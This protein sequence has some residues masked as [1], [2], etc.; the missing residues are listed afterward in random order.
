MSNAMHPKGSV[1]EELPS[2]HGIL[3]L[4]RP[5][6]LS[7]SSSVFQGS[8]SISAI[9]GTISSTGTDAHRSGRSGRGRAFI[10][11]G[12]RA[13]HLVTLCVMRAFAACYF[14][15]HALQVRR[16]V[17]IS[18][19]CTL[20]LQLT[21]ASWIMQGPDVCKRMQHPHAAAFCCKLNC[22]RF[23][24]CIVTTILNCIAFPRQDGGVASHNTYMSEAAAAC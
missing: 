14:A 12:V 7:Q 15:A 22:T 4:G 16:R 8:A 17:C 6:R 19:P 3:S 13:D 20:P 1:Q 23:V 9:Q 10:L 21:K 2:E 18:H 5:S 11:L 24:Y